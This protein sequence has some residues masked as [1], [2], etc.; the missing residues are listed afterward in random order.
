MPILFGGLI[1]GASIAGVRRNLGRR[2]G[3]SRSEDEREAIVN[4]RAMSAVGTVL[5]IAL[6]GC[7]IFTLMRGQST[8]AYAALLAIGGTTYVVALVA[9][10]RENR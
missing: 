1:A 9:L 4:M 6:T 2:R 10:R 3:R 5:V 8:T 7:I